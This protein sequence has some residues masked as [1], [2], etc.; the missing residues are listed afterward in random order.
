MRRVKLKRRQFSL[1]YLFLVLTVV[2]VAAGVLRM[3][4]VES[5]EFLEW[6]DFTMLVLIG[7]GGTIFGAWLLF[8]A[9]RV[10]RIW[11]IARGKVLRYWIR[12]TESQ[13]FF[14]P[15]V[16]FETLDE[17]LVT[18]IGKI[19]WPWARWPKGSSILIHYHPRNPLWIEIPSP[20]NLW[21]FAPPLA[22]LALVLWILFLLD[23]LP[24]NLRTFIP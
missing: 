18:T 15:V 10:L 8:H 12:R 1:G 5:K 3:A 17:S 22:A 9:V 7:G 2:A 16:Q 6:V 23:K 19:G 13:S 21:G 11:P 24:V 14:F 20:G 4:V